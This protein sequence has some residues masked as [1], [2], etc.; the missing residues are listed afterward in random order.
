MERGLHWGR[1]MK[2]TVLSLLFLA[3][4]ASPALADHED[5]SGNEFGGCVGDTS[6]SSDNTGEQGCVLGDQA[7]TAGNATSLG[8][9]ALVGF[10]VTRR[11]VA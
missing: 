2:R 3:L 4:A 10:V 8:M 7:F 1:G 9:L 11:R 5:T 6:D